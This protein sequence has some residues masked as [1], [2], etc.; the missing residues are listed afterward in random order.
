MLVI[1]KMADAH[2]TLSLMRQRKLNLQVVMLD[3]QCS[4]EQ[5]SLNASVMN[6]FR[7]VVVHP[8]G[9]WH[10]CRF[11]MANEIPSLYLLQFLL[12]LAVWQIGRKPVLIISL[13]L[14]AVSNFGFG[15]VT[16][17][18]WSMVVRFINGLCNG[19]IN[20]ASNYKRYRNINDWGITPSPPIYVVAALPWVA[21]HDAEF[22]KLIAVD[23]WHYRDH[24]MFATVFAVCCS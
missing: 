21:F 22:T 15:F 9:Y 11:Q 7:V 16:T 1:G 18:P 19:E 17:L 4:G 8:C 23:H 14:V 3:N 10:I 2:F 24:T 13:S 20:K 5:C 6:G 12:G